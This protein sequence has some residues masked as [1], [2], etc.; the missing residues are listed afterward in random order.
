MLENGVRA[1]NL[2]KGV[3]RDVYLRDE[4]HS[5]ERRSDALNVIGSLQ[6]KVVKGKVK[7]KRNVVGLREKVKEG[8]RERLIVDKWVGGD[9]WHMEP[10]WKKPDEH[11]D[12]VRALAITPD[13]QHV[14]SGS[15]DKSVRCWAVDTGTLV[16]EKE[17]AHSGSVNALAITPDGQ[18]VIS[19]SWGKMTCWLVAGTGAPVWEKQGAHDGEGGDEGNFHFVGASSSGSGGGFGAVGGVG[20][21]NGQVKGGQLPGAVGEGKCAL[22]LRPRSGHHAG[23]GARHLGQ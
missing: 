16:W 9:S 22:R 11:S 2:G 12:S 1:E 15:A 23:R 4:R 6:E 17:N 14:I 5:D 18:H 13:G 20:R 3:L 21:H 7:E 19:G 8:E 10:V